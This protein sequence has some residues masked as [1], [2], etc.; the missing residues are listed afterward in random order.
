MLS[1]C[2]FQLLGTVTSTEGAAAMA[3]AAAD[4]TSPL[5]NMSTFRRRWAESEVGTIIEGRGEVAG[6]GGG[7]GASS[8]V[9][10]EAPVRQCLDVGGGV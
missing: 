2:T 1:V 4:R 8:G 5:G 10:T 7:G 3:T 6:D 9:V